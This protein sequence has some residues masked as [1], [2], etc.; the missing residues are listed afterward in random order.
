M[1]NKEELGDFNTQTPYLSQEGQA[2]TGCNL[3]KEIV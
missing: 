3:S 2:E 1:K